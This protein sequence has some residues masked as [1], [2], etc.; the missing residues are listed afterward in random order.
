MIPYNGTICIS[1]AQLVR[2]DDNP[3]GVLS[4]SNY[5]YY[6]RKGQLEIV[7]RGGGEGN[8][9]LLAFESVPPKYKKKYK[10]V[11]K[12]D[13]NVEAQK[14]G[15]LKDIEI[16]TEAVDFFKLHRIIYSEGKQES[17]PDE[18]QELYVNN[19]AVLDALKIAWDKHVL[20]CRSKNKR[21]LTGEFWKNAAAATQRLLDEKKVIHDLPKNQRRLQ[22]KLKEYTEQGYA[23]LI[24]KKYAN[25][26]SRVITEEVGAWLV[27]RFSSRI[28]IVTLE[29]LFAEYNLL[30]DSRKW[31]KLKSVK[32][33]KDYLYLP[34]VKPLWYAAR[35]GELASKEEFSRQNRRKELT[36]R[37]T[38]WYSDGTKLN[39]FYRDEKGNVKTCNVYE[40]I[41]AYS[42]CFL[43]YH[44]S[45]SEDYEAQYYAF[46]MALQTAG[47][48][49]YELKY[50]NQGGHKKLESSN[51]LQNLARHAVKTA[52]Y[53]GKS[54]TI[55][56]AFGRFQAQFLHKEWYF[57][58]Q[59]ITATKKESH[60]NMEF[61]L[62]NTDKLC[63]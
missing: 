12:I 5:K 11:N 26:N 59:N 10:E 1:K 29:Q 42:E 31:D 16:K 45:Q 3:N 63:I 34:E 57:T 9:T 60:A 23:C 38:L 27:S 61:I 21:P 13:P 25:Q 47:H 53:N 48:K 18:V 40:V 58:G 20:A 30:A 19:A 8:S 15:L 24:S 56:S 17:L 39:Y 51:L 28:E 41:D 2:S 14:T 50:D 6:L 7:R 35:Y 32:A 37:D 46:K 44:I 49:P 55:E 36:R 43:G 33:V 54:K 4:L 22:E 62:A 52:P